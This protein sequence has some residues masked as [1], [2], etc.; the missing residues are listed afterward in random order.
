M[1]ENERLRADKHKTFLLIR[2]PC[3]RRWIYGDVVYTIEA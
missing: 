3:D 1:N 2:R